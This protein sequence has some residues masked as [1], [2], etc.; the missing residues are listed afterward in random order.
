M[1]SA[2]VF[3]VIGTCIVLC[4]CCVIFSLKLF[5]TLCEKTVLKRLLK[6]LTSNHN[7]QFN[8]LTLIII[9]LRSD[10]EKF[11]IAR[12]RGLLNTVSPPASVQL[13]HNYQVNILNVGT[14]KVLT[15]SLHHLWFFNTYYFMWW[16][17]VV[18]SSLV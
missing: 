18:V 14:A 17:G 8:Y 4:Y 5:S 11:E 10:L 1:M 13:N 3:T 2:A 7:F 9:K 15:A 16:R 12:L 6:V